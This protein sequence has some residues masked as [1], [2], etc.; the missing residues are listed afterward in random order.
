[1]Y[2][3]CPLLNVLFLIFKSDMYTHTHTHTNTH[4]RTHTHI[5]V[6]KICL[7]KAGLTNFYLHL[8]E[9]VYH[10]FLYKQNGS[11]IE[12]SESTFVVKQLLF[13]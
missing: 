11:A 1:M 7:D 12:Y 8:S 6:T 4:T 10:S 2:N 9:K 13:L 3:F 5:Y